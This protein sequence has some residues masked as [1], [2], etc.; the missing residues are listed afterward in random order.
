ME[1]MHQILLSLLPSFLRPRGAGLATT[2]HQVVALDGLR[3]WACLFVFNEHL[4]Y[5]FTNCFLY[6]YG[7][8]DKN[9]IIQ[10]PFMRVPWAGFAMVDIFYVISGY[11]LAYKPLKFM[12]AEETSQS[13]HVILSSLVRRAF[14]LYGPLFA[15]TFFTAIAVQS[16]LFEPGRRNAGQILVYPGSEP[17]PTRVPGLLRQ[18]IHWAKEC[19]LPLNIW[20]WGKER[21]MNGYD[22]HTWTVPVEYNTSLVLFLVLFAISRMTTRRRVILLSGFVFYCFC[23]QRLEVLTFTAG[24]LL[25]QIDL[26]NH[27]KRPSVLPTSCLNS[28]RLSVGKKETIFSF[29]CFLLGLFL[30]S[31]PVLN[32]DTTFGYQTLMRLLSVIFAPLKLVRQ[33][34]YIR[35]LGAIF[36]VYGSINCTWIEAFLSNRVSIYLGRISYALYLVH[37]P[38]IRSL[39]YAAVP[40]IYIL[41][42][43]GT[44]SGQ[45][46]FTTV[47]AWLLG[48]LLVFPLVIWLSDLFWRFVDI[49]CVKFARTAESYLNN[50]SL[51]SGEILPLAK[52]KAK[53]RC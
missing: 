37:G 42:G 38:V 1:F 11:V 16:G 13:Q 6:G 51:S 26:L 40:T 18:L 24:A 5:V 22:R 31:A 14:R 25:A 17:S 21:A 39:L 53:D 35:T 50:A 32:T 36:V 47:Q 15:A 23:Y 52:T 46:T 34:E 7:T 49:P 48:A 27:L 9:R 2:Q 28:E 3:G 8:S 41:T 30:C 43:D 12:Q 33:A 19:L 44:W 10:H 4:T 29:L 45:T 20:Q